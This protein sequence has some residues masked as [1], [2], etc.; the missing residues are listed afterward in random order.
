MWPLN[1]IYKNHILF[2]ALYM[3][4]DGG[5]LDAL[6]SMECGLNICNMHA[7]HG[8]YASV[9]VFHAFVSSRA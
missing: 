3:H 9:Y 6:G 8:V 2:H 1:Q 5:F 4:G 7:E